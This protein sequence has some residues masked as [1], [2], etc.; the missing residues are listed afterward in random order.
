MRLFVNTEMKRNKIVICIG[1]VLSCAALGYLIY[2][3]VT[4]DNYAVFWQSFCEAGSAGY[5]ALCIAVVLLPVQLLIESRKWQ[6]M[7]SGLVPVSYKDAFWQV[8]YGNV[9][10]FVTP[11][12]LGEYPG[13]IIEMG[14]EDISS[15]K[16]RIFDGNYWKDWRKWLRVLLLHLARYVVWMIQLWAVLTFCGILLSPQ[17]AIV[18]II[19]YYFLITFMPS[20]P[21]AE[22][23]FKGGWAVLI[24]S[25]FTENVPAIAVTVTIVWLINTVIPVVVG[26]V[27]RS[28][29]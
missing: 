16:S 29:K 21:A 25:H 13:R 10:A 1:W 19:S 9:A 5:V 2:R 18:A 20:V 23:A 27:F 22:V 7:L 17:E 4:Y 6:T 15:V 14:I 11:Y 26:I 3:L 8:I 28:K 24:F 12:R